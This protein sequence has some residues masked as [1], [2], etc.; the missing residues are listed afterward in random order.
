VAAACARQIT[1]E[2]P[3]RRAGNAPAEQNVC[4]LVRRNTS[5]PVSGQRAL[6]TCKLKQEPLSTPCGS[7][8]CDPPRPA[9]APSSLAPSSLVSSLSLS[10]SLSS[11]LVS[12]PSSA[13]SAHTKHLAGHKGWTNARKRGGA[14]LRSSSLRAACCSCCHCVHQSWGGV[15]NHVH[16]R[17]GDVDSLAASAPTAYNGLARQGHLGNNHPP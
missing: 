13:P 1:L 12:S 9:T 4:S 5:S 15:W 10:L 14:V 11:S 17:T 2:A 16:G 7:P 3:A 8:V 6:T